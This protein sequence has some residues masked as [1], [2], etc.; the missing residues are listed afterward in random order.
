MRN[1]LQALGVLDRSIAIATDEELSAIVDALSEDHREALEAMVD[2]DELDIVALRAAA[3][4]GRLDGGL[5]SIAIV[6][7][8]S[9]LADCIEQ[10]GDAADHPST[11]DLAKVL[12]GLIDR[13]GLAA[14][15]IMLAST[16]AGDAPA[17]S[18]IRDLLKNDDRFKL[19][20]AEMRP[21]APERPSP[22]ADDPERA[23][24]RER[25]RQQREERAVRERQRREQSRR[26]RGRA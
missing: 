23:A 15:R 16:V 25:R 4:A 11:E 22:R 19:P 5:E 3:T 6:L 20:A 10:L 7:S 17:A 9:C 18:V 14:T 13:H 2:A 26:D 24:V 8:D 1:R 21:V 12:P